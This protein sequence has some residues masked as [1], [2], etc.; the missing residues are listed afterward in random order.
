MTIFEVLKNAA[1][2]KQTMSY[3]DLIEKAN[4]PYDIGSIADR[5]AIGDDLGEISA[6]CDDQGKPLISALVIDQQKNMPGLGFF[7][8]AH[9]LGK[10]DGSTNEKKR[11]K[12]WIQELN[13][14]FNYDWE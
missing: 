13:E 2:Q 14:V 9:N 11:E 4:L 6:F 10:Y 5:T 1:K 8:L 12:Y 7:K 3:K